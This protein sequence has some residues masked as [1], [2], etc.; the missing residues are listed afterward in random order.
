MQMFCSYMQSCII[1]P[2]FKSLDV[3]HLLNN[4]HFIKLDLSTLLQQIWTH[5]G[6]QLKTHFLAVFGILT[7]T[8][9]LSPPGEFQRFMVEW[10]CM[11]AQLRNCAV[12]VFVH[13]SGW[14]CWRTMWIHAAWVPLLLI[15]GSLSSGWLFTRAGEQMHPLDADCAKANLKYGLR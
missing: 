2:S 6:F 1:L 12:A 15:A 10:V 5:R 13:S 8:T 3:V 14:A 11:G 7:S 4:F 9:N